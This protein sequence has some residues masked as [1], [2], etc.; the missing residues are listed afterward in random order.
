MVRLG[1]ETLKEKLDSVQAVH[2]LTKTYLTEQEMCW[3]MG[4]KTAKK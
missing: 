3:I 1:D 4:I 2:M